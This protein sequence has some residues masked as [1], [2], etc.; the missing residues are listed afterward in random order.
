MYLL[1]KYAYPKDSEYG[2]FTIHYSMETTSGIITYALGQ[3]IMF[4]VGGVNQP[5]RDIVD[6]YVREKA[7]AYSDAVLTDIFIRIYY[8]QNLSSVEMNISNDQIA[9]LIAES[10]V[11]DEVYD[12]IAVRKIENRKRKYLKHITRLKPNCKERRSF[13]V[14][15]TETILVESDTDQIEKVH[16]PYAVGFVVVKPDSAPSKEQVGSI[17]TYFSEE[18]PVF[19]YDT[20]RKR[21]YKMLTEF[22]DRLAHGVKPSFQDLQSDTFPLCYLAKPA[23]SCAKVKR[24]FFLLRSFFFYICGGGLPEKGGQLLSPLPCSIFLF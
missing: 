21:S 9:R 7:E 15:D 14:A 10:V 17:E 5:V 22:I 4:R 1:F 12:R 13:I 8:D 2:K 19:L 3:A 6:E 11:S 24:L 20:F 23:T 16:M 18:Y